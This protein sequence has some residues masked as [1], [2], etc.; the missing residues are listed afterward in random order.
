ML[1]TFLHKQKIVHGSATC[2][3]EKTVRTSK[4]TDMI[5]AWIQTRC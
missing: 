2:V 5:M 4:N 3:H 1:K